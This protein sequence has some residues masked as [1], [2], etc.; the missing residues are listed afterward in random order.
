MSAT[1]LESIYHYLQVTPRIGSAGQPRQEQFGAIARAGYEVVINLHVPDVQIGPEGERVLVN[2]LGMAY[3]HI[4]VAWTEPTL[5]DLDEFFA[6]MDLY[7]DRKVMVHCAANARASCFLY[8]YRAL[9]LGVD[10]QV[11]ERA[12]LSIWEPNATW[13]RFLQQAVEHYRA[14][15]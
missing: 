14:N 12:M 13:S 6:A 15:H 1:E 5:A 3:V 10:P 4:P 7:R 8:L 2:Q 9:R 11:A